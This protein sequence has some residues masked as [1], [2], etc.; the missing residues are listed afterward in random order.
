MEFFMTKK[1]RIEV[2]GWLNGDDP[3]KDRMVHL[4]GKENLTIRNVLRY[5][6]IVNKDGLTYQIVDQEFDT[7]R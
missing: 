4:F 7:G 5:T 6:K 1:Y 3:T 2:Y